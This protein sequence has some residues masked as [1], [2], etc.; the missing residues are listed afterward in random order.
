MDNKDW[1]CGE[2]DCARCY[3]ES[4]RSGGAFARWCEE[5]VHLVAAHDRA[6][7]RLPQEPAIQYLYRCLT[8]E[9]LDAY[10][11]GS[12]A[13]AY[14]AMVMDDDEGYGGGVL[15]PWVER[16]ARLESEAQ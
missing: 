11:A 3:P 7:G 12:T 6:L 5:V 16:N 9:P 13:I 14:A 4:E 2:E 8:D 10:E 1:N 15:E